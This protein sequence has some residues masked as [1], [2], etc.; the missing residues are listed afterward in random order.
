MLLKGYSYGYQKSTY[1]AAY[2]RE[3]SGI[4]EG[5]TGIKNYGHGK[6]EYLFC[7]AV[8]QTVFKTKA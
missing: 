6:N 4:A 5:E 3:F 2:L 1:K 7:P 8:F